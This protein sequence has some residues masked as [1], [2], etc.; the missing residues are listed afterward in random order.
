MASKAEQNALCRHARAPPSRVR[1]TRLL[2]CHTARRPARRVV[3]DTH[4]ARAMERRASGGGEARAELEGRGR[5]TCGACRLASGWRRVRVV[6][7]WTH[8]RARRQ[9]G[10]L[11][12]VRAT[13]SHLW[14][15]GGGTIAASPYLSPACV[16]PPIYIFS[17]FREEKIEKMARCFASPLGNASTRS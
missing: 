14:E 3:M 13:A 11:G 5:C 9:L 2:V 7:V 16:E 4:G 15:A 6:G 10:R 12:G 1:V 17:Y 8:P